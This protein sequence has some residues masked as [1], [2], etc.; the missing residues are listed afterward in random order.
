M[1]RPLNALVMHSP[2]HTP[3]RE[4]GRIERP[5]RSCIEWLAVRCSLKC[6]GMDACSITPALLEIWSGSVGKDKTRLAI[7]Q[8]L[9]IV[10]L[11]EESADAISCDFY[12]FRILAT[13]AAEGRAG[14][15]D[16]A[17]RDFFAKI[18]AGLQAYI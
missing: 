8:A 6:C 18:A 4:I 1:R 17:E 12:D 14:G 16:E 11:C 13:P 10:Q 15:C 9:E 7:A 2:R 5:L 3:T